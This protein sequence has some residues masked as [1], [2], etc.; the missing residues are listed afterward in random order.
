M[1]RQARK[2]EHLKFHA[3]LEISM[4]QEIGAMREMLANMRQEE[5]CLLAGDQEAWNKI[6][7]ERSSLLER[8]YELRSVRVIATE[9]LENWAKAEAIPIEN[10]FCTDDAS[11]CEILSMREQLTALIEKMNQQ[12]VRNLTLEARKPLPSTKDSLAFSAPTLTS[13]LKK[14]KI[15]VITYPDSH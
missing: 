15:G 3:Q 2:P 10:I 13:P 7:M 5:V 6:M 9:Q 1:N 8:L 4:K 11:S 12:N 14:G